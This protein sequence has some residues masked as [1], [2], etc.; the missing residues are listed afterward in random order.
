MWLTK[1]DPFKI[2]VWLSR[3]FVND[4]LSVLSQRDCRS[5]TEYI[6]LRALWAQHCPV[7]VA[8]LNSGGE[9]YAAGLYTWVK[10]RFSN[11]FNGSRWWIVSS[12]QVYSV[13][14][15]AIKLWPSKTSE[16]TSDARCRKC[17]KV[18][19]SIVLPTNMGID[20]TLPP[21]GNTGWMEHSKDSNN[22]PRIVETQRS[23]HCITL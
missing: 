3:S 1:E 13:F 9:V 6:T 15:L 2:R 19:V 21:L 8:S 7:D 5:W 23:D 17:R 10:L 11:I 16:C 4:I 12:Y 22:A 18:N 20:Y 14:W